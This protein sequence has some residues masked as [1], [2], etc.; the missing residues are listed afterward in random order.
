MPREMPILKHKGDKLLAGKSFWSIPQDITIYAFKYLT[1]SETQLLIYLM[2]NKPANQEEEFKGWQL[3]NLN[4]CMGVGDRAVRD[5]RKTL[6]DMGF[7]RL[8][9]GAVDS[10]YITIEVD[11]DWIREVVSNDWDKAT[12]KQNYQKRSGNTVPQ[13]ASK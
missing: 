3:S 11:F 12:A 5:A 6:A 4:D 13:F 1:Y 9:P 8:K 7:V 2:G 10:T